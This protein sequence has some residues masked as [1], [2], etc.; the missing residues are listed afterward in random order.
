LFYG[1]DHGIYELSVSSSDQD[2]AALGA[3][4][5]VNELAN[6]PGGHDGLFQGE[7]KDIGSLE[8]HDCRNLVVWHVGKVY[9]AGN[10]SE[11]RCSCQHALFAE[12]TLIPEFGEGISDCV[13]ILN[14]AIHDAPWC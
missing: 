12:S 10:H 4:C 9:F 1:L 14:L 3:I 11:P 2:P 13:D 6:G 7:G 8:L 5:W